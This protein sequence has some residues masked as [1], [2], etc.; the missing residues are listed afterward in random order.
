MDEFAKSNRG[1]KIGATDGCKYALIERIL[2]RA[3]IRTAEEEERC[4]GFWR[5]DSAGRGSTRRH[6]GMPAQRP[7]FPRRYACEDAALLAKDAAHEEMSGPAVRHILQE[8]WRCAGI[9]PMSAWRESRPRTF[10]FCAARQPT[11][12][13]GCEWQTRKRARC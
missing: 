8:N 11:A 9:V 2:R 1:V 5:R 12:S 6:I 3:G 10:T 4:G 7:K 13:C